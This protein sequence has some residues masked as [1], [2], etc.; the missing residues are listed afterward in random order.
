MSASRAVRRQRPASQILWHVWLP[1]AV[2]TV[3]WFISAGSDSFYFP[4]AQE[5]FAKTWTVWV[6]D[7]LVQDLWPS[8]V[9]LTIGYLLAVLLGIAIG[10]ILGLVKPLE[11]ALRPLTET[12][13]A[14]P[15]VALLP[16]SMMFFGAG[17]MMK[18]VMITFIA[19][20]PI[21]LNTIEGVRGID[22]GLRSVMRSFRV[23]RG[24]RF[25]FVFLPAAM[26]QIFA[27]ARI[28]LAIAVAVMVAVEMYGTPGGI[29]Y[30]IRSAQQTFRIVDMWTGLVVLGIFGYVLNVLFR[31]FEN[32]IL[33]WH[34]RMVAHIQGGS[35]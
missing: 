31:V 13:R 4:P 29:G 26:P 34:H 22:P 30:F 32:R 9:R 35:S 16:I 24:D 28:S 7:G 11:I 10:V 23:S 27:G 21:M 5:V 17:D 14:I 1:L 18:L 12:A 8:L 3:V 25:R 33:R 20:W 6:P 2:L 19:M 15:G